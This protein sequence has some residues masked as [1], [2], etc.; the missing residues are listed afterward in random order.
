[1]SRPRKCRICFAADP[2]ITGQINALLESG[3]KLKVIAEQVPGFSVYQL[4][5]HKRNCLAPNVLPESD[6]G[7][8]EISKWLGRAES[9]FLVAQSNG[10]ARSAV[11]AIS[12]AVRA[13]TSLHKQMEREE[14]K[15]AGADDPN[16]LTIEKL[17]KAVNEYANRIENE[18][19]VCFRCGQ[20]LAGKENNVALTAN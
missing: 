13:L 8:T 11:S 1:M 2:A 6:A 17:D 18:R 9:T 10:D 20:P 4:S 5:R 19:G 12:T 15:Q 3:V 14:E 7:S 16:A